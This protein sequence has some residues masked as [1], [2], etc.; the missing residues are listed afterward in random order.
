MSWQSAGVSDTGLVRER[1]EDRYWIDAEH[2]VFLVVDGVGG[3]AAGELAAQTAVDSIRTSIAQPGAA[4][5]RVRRAITEANNRIFD[6]AREHAE[7]KGMACVLTLAVVEEG[8]VTIGHVGDSR[9]Y[10]IWEGAMRKMTSDHSPVG[11]GEEAGQFTER[12]AMRHPRR[13]EVFRDV[14]SRR[15]AADDRDFIE[16]RS[17]RFRPD[18]ALLLCSDG[19]TD[20]LT[21]E[22]VR[23]IVNRYEGDPALVAAELVD[24]ANAAGGSDNITALFVAGPEFR[25]RSAVTR[26]RTGTTRFRGMRRLLAGRTALV[27]YGLLLAM[28]MWALLRGAR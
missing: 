15:R 24:A 2:G 6:R 16:I 26:P 11:E 5:E 13:N 12:E 23:E 14:G 27:I 22:Q 28:A 9:L 21:S 17:C 20:L 8:Q 7:H 25:G 19:L 1:N 10:L 4:E 3:H 18:A